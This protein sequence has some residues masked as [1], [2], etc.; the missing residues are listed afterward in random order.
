M[1]RGMHGMLYSSDAAAT[2]AFFR[3][4]LKLHTNDIGHGWLIFD[5]PEADLGVHPADDDGGNAGTHDLSF[6]CDDI[7]GTVAELRERGV[8]F[9]GEVED[10]GWGLVTNID[11]PGGLTL[12]LY[13]PRYR[14]G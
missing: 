4:Q 13:E 8:K 10:R 9:K 1:I 5:L 2:R 11:V 14:K 3:E 12:M 7:Q 6:Y